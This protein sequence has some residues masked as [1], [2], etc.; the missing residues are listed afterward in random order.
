ML[1][2][3]QMGQKVFIS[4]GHPKEYAHIA[5]GNIGS[6][7]YGYIVG[8]KEAA[9]TIIQHALVKGDN[10][11]LDTTVY[12]ACFLYRQYLELTLKDIY[13]SNS[14]ETIQEK[15]KTLRGC[16]HNLR[17]I[18]AK[19]KELI[20]DDFSDGDKV[21]LKAVESYINQFADEDSN[22]FTFRY[23]VTKDL[24]PVHKNEKIINLKN[25]AKRMDE[26]ETFLSAV[27][28][29]MDVHRDLENKMIPYY[30]IEFDNYY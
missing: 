22:S 5:W 30:A 26:L 6:Q 27:S 10:R 14:K 2:F 13:L 17:K 8:Y 16:Q 11:T 24:D 21:I 12:P 20:I 9:D 4:S 29:G 25:L 18:W 28:T 19:A 7:F 15:E 23:P 3:P 1:G